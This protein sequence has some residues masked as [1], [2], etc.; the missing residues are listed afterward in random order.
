[1]EYKQAE[2]A[3]VYGVPESTISRAL[4]RGDLVKN[5]GGRID[6]ENPRN[7]KYLSERRLKANREA[8]KR[9]GENE[10]TGTEPPRNAEARPMD[11]ESRL[12][13]YRQMSAMTIR[14][15]II[16]YGS[17]GS[18]R[19]FVLL[20]RDMAAADEKDQ[21][22]KERRLELIE[23]EFVTAHVFQY[24]DVLNNQLLEWP[25]SYAD[26]LVSLAQAAG[27]N[28]KADVIRVV[29]DGIT[30]IIQGA[31][32]HVIKEI[33]SMRSKYQKSVD[34]VSERLEAIENKIGD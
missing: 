15:A 33:N 9:S 4:K 32:D 19:E 20:M 28:A 16:T 22:T 3:R 11:M 23:K 21:R 10:V 1:M 30:K 5:S 24:L 18:M 17:A 12:E 26:T 13:I 14:E 27:G 34:D 29:R 25:E 6:D 2:L 7:V 8:V 31:K